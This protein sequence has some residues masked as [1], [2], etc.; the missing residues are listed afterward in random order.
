LAELATFRASDGYE[1]Y[2]RRWLR[3]DARGQV[4]FVHG[5]RS[6]GGWYERSCSQIAAAGIDVHFLDR[7]GA[8]LNTSRRGDCPNFR[9]LLDDVVEYLQPLRQKKLPIAIAGI[10]W[11]GK[12]AAGLSYRAPGLVDAVALLC[13]GLCPKVRPPFIQ[14]LEILR[15]KFRD[16][17]KFFPV[18]LNEPEL[19][20]SSFEWQRFIREDRFGLPQATARFLYSSVSFDI[21]LKRAIKRIAAPTL[22]ML[23]GEDRIIDNAATRKMFVKFGAR[24]RTIIDYAGTHHTLEFEGDGHPFVKDL[25]DWLKKRS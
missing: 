3:S 5:I 19:F 6:H 8:G 16:P 1:F 10:S 22:L 25:I 4:I 17:T 11:G 15:A 23:A 12:L 18:P 13:P 9:R 20:T 24:D 21:Y 2:L 7:R 14:R